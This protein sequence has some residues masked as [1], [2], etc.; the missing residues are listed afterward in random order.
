V[1]DIVT[2]LA[3]TISAGTPI[4]YAIIGDMI[5]QKTG[6]ISLSVEGSMLLGACVGFGVA[7]YTHNFLL[8]IVAGAIAGG[9]IGVFQA[10]LAIYRGANMMASGFVL[11]F[12]AQ[13]LTA[14]F[15]KS[16]L[17]V[18]IDITTKASIPFL[19]QIPII[20]T[21]FFN[22]DM[23][24][25][26]SFILPVITHIFLK[27]TRLGLVICSVGENPDVTSAYGYNPR[28]IQFCAV[29]F[30][31]M[32]AGIGG[33]Q[34]ST[35]YTMSWANNL[36]NGRGFIASALVTLCLWKPLN[37]YMAAYLFGLAQALQVYLQ[38]HS[39]PISMYVTLMLPYLMTII[40]LGIISSSK[41]K[42]NMMPEK[43]KIIS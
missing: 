11:M 21:T 25:Y 26:V 14:F 12:L 24:T 15:G 37:A 19:D 33:V 30:A 2:L 22:Q 31:G 17:G 13:G 9:L 40:A 16:L 18:S 6:I 32:L 1:N 5:G 35:V 27:R 36:V 3:C 8:A 4:L 23:L 10:V 42:R 41:T 38:I 29:V 43:L 34:M 39:V 7:F 28:T 20:G